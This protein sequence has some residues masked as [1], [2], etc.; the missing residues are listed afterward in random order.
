[1]AEPGNSTLLSEYKAV[2][3]DALSKYPGDVQLWLLRGNAEEASPSGRG[4]RG[5][6]PSLRFYQQALV[7]S[8]DNFAAHHYLTHSY[9]NIGRIQDALREGA[10]FARL[11]PAIPHAHH[12]YGHD[13]RRVGRMD[14]AIKEFRKAYDLENDYYR[15][16]AIPSQYDWH[17][18]HNLDLLSTSYQ[19]VGQMKTAEQLMRE[20]FSAPATEASLEFNKK[21]LP[22]FL[23]DRGRTREALEA[24]QVLA[25]DNS[26]ATSVMGRIIASHAL[27]SLGRLAEASAQAKQALIGAQGS[28]EISTLLAPYLQ[29]LQGE[30]YL[31]T[32]Q[33]EKGRSIL[34]SVESQVRSEPGPDAWSQA[35]FTLE[36]IGRLAREAGDW[37][38]AQYTARQME[39]HDPYYAG[40]HYAVAIV[41]EHNG[42]ST[43]A[44]T[45]FKL[46]LKYWAN[47]D[48]DLPELVEARS[49]LGSNP[50]R[51]QR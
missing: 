46:T 7:L 29:I 11:A 8:E 34:K 28:R 33:M 44:S 40:S 30:F 21:E 39:Q 45:E 1:M 20:S 17:H 32:G 38:L 48:R 26:Q 22:L 4:Q 15:A 42:D 35:L 41:A 14:E 19:Y 3:D 31:R 13:L 16:E 51:R 25:A 2:I 50:A 36:R 27:M 5:S 6:E 12:M 10:A 24:A 49:I 9:E 47:A 18:Q 43:T 23:L 37:E